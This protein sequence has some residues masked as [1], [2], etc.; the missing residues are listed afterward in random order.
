M[1]EFLKAE[2]VTAKVYSINLRKIGIIKPKEQSL[3][4]VRKLLYLYTNMKDR[5]IIVGME[6]GALVQTKRF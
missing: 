4:T 3:S 1:E 6:K 2:G 5:K